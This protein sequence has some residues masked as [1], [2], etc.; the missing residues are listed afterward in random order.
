MHEKKE[1]AIMKGKKFSLCLAALLMF[2]CL[3]ACDE[4]EKVPEGYTMETADGR[5]FEPASSRMYN[6]CSSVIVNDTCDK[7]DMWYCSNYSNGADGDYIFYRTGLKVNG[8]WCWSQPS[9]ALSHGEAG[10]WDSSG[11]CDPS[12]IKGEFLYDGENYPYLMAYLGGDEAGNFGCAF[13]FA[14]AKEKQGPWVKIETEDLCPVLDVYELYPNVSNMEAAHLWGTGQ[15]CVMSVDKKG[16]ILL[17]YT[18]HHLTGEWGQVVE[19]WDMSDLNNPVQEFSYDIANTGLKRH[20][21]HTASDVIT[22]ADF[23]YDPVRQVMYVGTDVHPF[24]AA[25]GFDDDSYPDN[26]PRTA[27]VAFTDMSMEE[28]MLGDTFKAL[29]GG[30]VWTDLLQIDKEKTGYGRNS[31]MSFFRDEYGWMPQKDKI[32]IG[33]TTSNTSPWEDYALIYSWRIHRYEY[34]LVNR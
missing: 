26:I 32:E 12:V 17:F 30:V 19:R 3:G 22:N 20:S 27:R 18:K 33:Y 14:V 24:G 21:G 2:S 16:K 25:A 7:A 8:T 11:V 13:G 29:Q 6:Y 15:P 1:N 5:M 10:A 9:V 23:M 34:S 28:T 31:N 4:T